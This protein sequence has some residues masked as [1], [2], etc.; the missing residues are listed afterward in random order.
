[1]STANRVLGTTAP[2]GR[3]FCCPDLNGGGRLRNAEGSGPVQ[4][5]QSKAE[6]HSSVPGPSEPKVLALLYL[7]RC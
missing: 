5:S 7:L 3:F 4:A 2:R 1:M 6:R